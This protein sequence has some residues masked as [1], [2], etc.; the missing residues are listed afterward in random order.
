MSPLKKTPSA[1][2]CE[3]PAPPEPIRG[4]Q[5]VSLKKENIG[6]DRNREQ[7]IALQTYFGLP[8][9]TTPQSN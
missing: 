4:S 8:R 7:W 2:A 1:L 3:R 5:A 6:R 9:L